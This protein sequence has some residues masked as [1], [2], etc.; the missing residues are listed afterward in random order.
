MAAQRTSSPASAPRSPWV[1]W[2]IALAALPVALALA[3]IGLRVT[4]AA[5]NAEA[6][7]Q[8]AQLSALDQQ[9]T[10]LAQ[11]MADERSGAAAFI[12]GGRPAAGL[13]AL[14]RQYVITDAQA[15]RVRQLASQ[16]DHGS[17]AQT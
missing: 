7:G 9:V 2:L 3:F 16:V 5:R 4:N 8:V 13:P 14:H 1:A 12:A 6:Y 17:S 15:A 10:G 11:A